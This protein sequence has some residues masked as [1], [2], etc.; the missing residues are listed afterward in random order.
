MPQ[1]CLLTKFSRLNSHVYKNTECVYD[2]LI[3]HCHFAERR[4]Q[5]LDTERG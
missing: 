3:L 5:E 4:C 2:Q 1:A